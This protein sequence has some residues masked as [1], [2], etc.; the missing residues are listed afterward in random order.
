MVHRIDV[1]LVPAA[2]RRGDPADW[3]K[4]CNIV[5]VVLGLVA[6]WSVLAIDASLHHFGKDG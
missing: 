3:A 6:Y 2:R 1:P 4:T 5:S